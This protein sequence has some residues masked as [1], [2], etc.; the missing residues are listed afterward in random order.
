MYS[1]FDDGLITKQTY[2]S[3]KNHVLDM[4]DL[5]DQKKHD[6]DAVLPFAPLRH[7]LKQRGSILSMTL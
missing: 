2:T 7:L 3:L 6:D 4:H 5:L 1:L